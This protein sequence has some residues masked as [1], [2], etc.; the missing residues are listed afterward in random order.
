VSR[1]AEGQALPE[2]ALV[3]P[4]FLFVA[5][6]IVQVGL[7]MAG[8]VALV[9]GTRDAARAAVTYRVVGSTATEAA[10]ALAGAEIQSKLAGAMPGF[11]TARLRGDVTYSQVAG[12]TGGAAFTVVTIHASYAQP[13]VIPLVGA[14]LDRVDGLGAPGWA[15]AGDTYVLGATETMRLEGSA[16]GGTVTCAF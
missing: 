15:P 8:D 1:R 3:L 4:I 5:F 10:C 11:T 7:L 6:A 13:L 14:I 16:G 12:P 2:F 9:N